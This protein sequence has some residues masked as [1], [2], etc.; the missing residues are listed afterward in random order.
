MYMRCSVK[1]ESGYL[2]LGEIKGNAGVTKIGYRS[3]LGVIN[4]KNDCGDDYTTI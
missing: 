2:G 1:T 4:T 3:L